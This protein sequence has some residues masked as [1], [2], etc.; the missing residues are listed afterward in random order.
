MS[1]YYI[2]P[3]EESTNSY[4]SKTYTIFSIAMV[5][6][7]VIG[8]FSYLFVSK[9]ALI[10]IG[11]ANAIM[12]IACGWFG[13]RRPMAMVYPLFIGITGLLLGQLAHNYEIVFA[14]AAGLSVATFLGLS[15]YVWIKKADF[16]FL[17]GFLCVS[18]FILLGGGLLSIAF[19]SSL[20]NL[21]LSGFG[22]LVFACWILYDT[23]QIIHRLDADLT[24]AIAAF[25]LILDI[26][27]FFRWLLEHLFDLSSIW[28]FISDD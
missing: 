12:W 18:F 3:S 28:S 11:V 21:L 7:V 8:V 15:L 10:P 16:S 20:Y 23:S 17:S 14:Q 27:G 26:V 5:A 2:K 24:P 13:W 9:A 4:I 25:E 1:S 6:M 22:V 19:S